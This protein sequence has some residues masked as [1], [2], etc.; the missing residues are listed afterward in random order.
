MWKSYHC[1]KNVFKKSTKKSKILEIMYNSNWN[2]ISFF[3]CYKS[4]INN[5]QIRSRV[6]QALYK[7]KNK[8]NQNEQNCIS[9]I[10]HIINWL[11]YAF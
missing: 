3:T 6:H 7:L 5:L 11:L 2:I 8:L 1:T 10:E 4:H 9:I